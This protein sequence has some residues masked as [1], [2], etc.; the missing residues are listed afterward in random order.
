MSW[1]FLQ[2]E[3]VAADGLIRPTIGPGHLTQR[4]AHA[5]IQAILDRSP[6][7]APTA[8]TWRRGAADNTVYADRIIWAIYEHPDGQD[9]VP[10][11]MVW[12]EDFARIMRTAGVDVQVAR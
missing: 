6:S 10:A 3:I 11:A 7:L 1:N 4:K 2:A 12:L 8:A 5:E 9:P